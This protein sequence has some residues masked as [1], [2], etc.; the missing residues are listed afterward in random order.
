MIFNKWYCWPSDIPVRMSCPIL[1]NIP[2]SCTKPLVPQLF[3]ISVI[4]GSVV[5][6]CTGTIGGIDGIEDLPQNQSGIHDRDHP[7]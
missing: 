4:V 6:V 7:K 2:I 1:K 5:L 3:V